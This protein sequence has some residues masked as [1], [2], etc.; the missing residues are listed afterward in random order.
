GANAPAQVAGAAGAI[1]PL[2][3]SSTIVMAPYNVNAQNIRTRIWNGKDNYFT[4][5]LTKLKGDHLIQFGGQYQHN[6]NYH[7]RT[8]N[9]GTINYYPVYQIGDNSGAGA[10][11]LSS[12]GAAFTSNPTLA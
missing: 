5:N 1:E 4:D 6:W 10:V 2:G 8:D 7:Q 12:L 9:G 11:D 3:E